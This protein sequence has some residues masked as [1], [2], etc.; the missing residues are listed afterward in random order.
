MSNQRGFHNLIN[1]CDIISTTFHWFE[2]VMK[3]SKL[4]NKFVLQA[5]QCFVKA[6]LLFQTF[7]TNQLQC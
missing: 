4:L 2:K 6:F 1:K 5:K 7:F 3:R